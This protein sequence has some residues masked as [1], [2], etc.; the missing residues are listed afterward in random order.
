MKAS[1]TTIVAVVI[2]SL[3]AC[4]NN[5]KEPIAVEARVSV[6]QSE[7]KAPG[8]DILTATFLGDLESI[9]EH[10][11]A[12]SDLDVREPSVNSTPL[13]VAAVF[14][15]T[16]IARALIEG[17]AN[18]NLQNNEGS[19]ALHSA[20]FLCRT[21]IVKMLLDNGADKDLENNYGSTAMA[22]VSGPFNMVKTIYDEISKSL[23]PLGLKLDYTQIEETRPVIA[24]LLQ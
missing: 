1:L 9:R 7:I 6:I 22:T 21:E 19:T 20:A 8:V 18:V 2:L 10:V 4:V 15:K 12:G 23:G 11:R 14:G 13:I 17:G 5:K 3:C 24:T 16:D